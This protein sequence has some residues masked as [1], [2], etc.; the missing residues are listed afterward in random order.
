MRILMISTTFRLP[1]Q[2][3]RCAQAAGSSVYIL[4]TRGAK[5]LEHS[6]YCKGFIR[7]ARPIAGAFDHALAAEINRCSRTLDIQMIVPADISSTRSLIAVTHLLD[8]PCFPM[9]DLS[10]F[11]L[12]NDKWQ[13]NQLCR[14]LEITCPESHL[15]P[16]VPSLELEISRFCTRRIAKP[17]SMDGGVGCVTF[18]RTDAPKSLSAIFYKPVLVQEFIPGEDI[19]TGVFCVSGE[20]RAFL[21][22]RYHHQTHVTFFDEAIFAEIARLAR[23]LKL[24]GVFNF[25]MRLAKDGRIFFLECNPRFFIKL[26]MSMIAGINFVALGLGGCQAVDAPRQRGETT[27]RFPKAILASLHS[28]WSLSRK[29]W[30]ALKFVLRDPIPYMLEELHLTKN[31]PTSGLSERGTLVSCTPVTMAD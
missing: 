8:R 21:A 15:F 23:H 16:D 24:E 4:G 14:T 18:E 1:Y 25:D 3:M 5:G 6:R 17:L 12:L 7:S 29:D 11:D 13:F 10:A 9:P 26:A 19:S 31:V 28:P 27:I 22:Y 30:E 2:V 20:I